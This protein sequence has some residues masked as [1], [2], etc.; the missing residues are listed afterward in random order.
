MGRVRRK[1]NYVLQVCSVRFLRIA[2]AQGGPHDWL[3]TQKRASKC[4]S[5]AFGT[6]RQS[7]QIYRMS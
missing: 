7:P 4:G 3:L 5:V 1:G 6:S 2:G